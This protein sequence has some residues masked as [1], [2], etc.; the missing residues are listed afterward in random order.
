MNKVS[1]TFQVECP[2]MMAGSVAEYCDGNEVMADAA[3]QNSGKVLTFRTNMSWTK[4]QCIADA[5]NAEKD[6]AYADMAA[7]SEGPLGPLIARPTASNYICTMLFNG[8][9][10]QLA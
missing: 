9:R 6:S 1:F 7:A 2:C 3:V 4:V 5:F 10:V 8:Q